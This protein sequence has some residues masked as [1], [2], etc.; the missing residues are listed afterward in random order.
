MNKRTNRGTLLYYVGL[1]GAICCLIGAELIWLPA[2]LTTKEGVQ[3]IEI[4]NWLYYGLCLIPLSWA[5]GAF[6]LL[7]KINVPLM[8]RMIRVAII[9]LCCIIIGLI[10]FAPKSMLVLLVFVATTV[11]LIFIDLLSSEVKERTRFPWRNGSAFI[12]IA[13]LLVLLLYPIGYKV[14]YPGMTLNLNR[15]GHVAGGN[16][17]GTINGVLV[18]DRPAVF[19]DR[20]FGRMFPLYQFEPVQ[21]D[22]PSI[23]ETYAQVAAMK[24]DANRIAAAIAMEK[25]GLGKGA[26]SNGIRIIAIVKDS[27]A[28]GKLQAGDIIDKLDGKSV[29]NAGDMIAYMGDSVKSGQNVAVTARRG[30]ETL[31]VNVG[32]KPSEQDANRAVIGLSVQTEVLLDTPREVTY[33]DYIAHVGGPSHGA[34]LTLAF[35]DQL[36]IGGVTKG[37]N[38]AGTGTIEAD[39]SIGMV[40]GIPQ[41][42]YAVSRTDADVFF[43]PKEGASDAIDA[44]P[45]LNVVPVDKLDDVLKWLDEYDK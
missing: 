22:E 39:G 10:T 11:V 40:G 9:A 41:K 16:S 30:N 14:T 36:T 29:K 4:I 27:P 15:Y 13:V 31:T 37:L 20:L 44:A 32:T 8:L 17:V 21:A 28:D 35:I 3:W 18:F 43:V 24:T 12:S 34:M 26:V 2:P 6:W 19:A 45:G 33:N 5:I 23:S 25:V 38:V 42:A 1:V 7:S